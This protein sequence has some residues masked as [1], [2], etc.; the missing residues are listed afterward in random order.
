[1][2][3]LFA[4]FDLWTDHLT[5][6]H[7]PPGTREFL[8]FEPLAQL[9]M[10]VE[11]NSMVWSGLL[12]QLWEITITALLALGWMLRRHRTSLALWFWMLVAAVPAPF[13][14]GVHAFATRFYYYPAMILCAFTTVT[15]WMLLKQKAALKIVGIIWL[16]AIAAAYF[17]W[18]YIPIEFVWVGLILTSIIAIIAGRENWCPPL[19][20]WWIPILAASSQII[21]YG[22][23][24][25]FTGY[26]ILTVFCLI[27]SARNQWKPHVA[28]A[29]FVTVL[30]L[31]NPLIVLSGSLLL[32]I[33]ITFAERHRKVLF[34]TVQ[35]LPLWERTKPT[36]I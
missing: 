3:I 12:P 32:S 27:C 9:R 33:A 17:H 25:P 30:T 10:M 2:A 28:P 19:M 14:A 4:L 13:G 16:A 6:L 23:N 15:I 34:A 24:I 18:R 7:A 29:I 26:F 21:I 20:M 5:H 8:A 36:I 31:L 1:M 11:F 35:R 22:W